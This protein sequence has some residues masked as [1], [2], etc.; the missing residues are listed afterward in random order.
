MDSQESKL[1]G[2][3]CLR[4]G[5]LTND[6]LA[7]G[8]REHGKVGNQRKLGEIL[9]E[10]GHL[11][12]E[13]LT[14]LLHE[15]EE[16]AQLTDTFST[17]DP[18]TP[19]KPPAR[20]GLEVEIKPP[21]DF[22]AVSHV[23]KVKP[24]REATPTPAPAPVPK[25]KSAPALRK[26]PRSSGMMDKILKQAIKLNAS[27]IHIHAGLPVQLRING[28]LK[29]LK[30]PP[31]DPTQSE[32][33][34][35]EI[36]TPKNLACLDEHGDVD[37]AYQIDGVGRYRGN[38]YRQRGSVDAVFRAIHARPPP[39]ESLGLPR[40]LARLAT[41]HQGMVLL[42]GPAGCGKSSTMA[43]LVD[44]VNEERRSHIITVEDPI[45]YLHPSKRCL[46]NQRQV[47]SHTESFASALRAALREDPDMLAI[48]ELRDLETVSLAMT[49]AETGHLVMATLHTSSVIRTVDRMVDVFPPRQQPQA[50]AM[51]SESLRAVVS[52]R[53]VPD[54]EG[55]RLI[56]AVEVLIVTPAVSHLVRER[57][58]HQI[59]SVLQ[60]GRSQG[61]CLL[62]DS[63]AAL[64]EEGTITQEAARRTA[65]DP[66]RF[67]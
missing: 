6:Q 13:Q 42:T 66:R 24:P 21:K 53:L 34:A 16:F 36:L 58:T 37:L 26:P 63:L 62:D 38:V 12:P 22:D 44:I 48:G 43:A 20:P 40:M 65:E 54:V 18:G 4:H 27:D 33:L 47:H 17:G 32:Q 9:V 67:T 3:L 8:I 56:P 35:L 10:Q 31:L 41:Y 50:C 46:V 61:M 45:E 23:V 11:T 7:E 57:K 14:A 39:L 5:L 28:R 19:R 64:V 30:M 59:L 49:A 15:Q 60:T 1:I 51:L 55:K 52:Q 2:R 25:P 29:S